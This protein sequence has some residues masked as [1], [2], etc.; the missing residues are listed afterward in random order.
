[1]GYEKDYFMTVRPEGA[2]I[3]TV[4]PL[5]YYGELLWRY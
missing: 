1:M 3:L 2:P 4:S 5:R